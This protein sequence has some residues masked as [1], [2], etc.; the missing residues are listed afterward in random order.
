[1]HPHLWV[2]FSSC[3]AEGQ[4]NVSGSIV[5]LS[6]SDEGDNVGEKSA[7]NKIQAQGLSREESRKCIKA[8]TTKPKTFTTEDA[9]GRKAVVANGSHRGASVEAVQ[10][11]DGTVSKQGLSTTSIN[12]HGQMRLDMQKQELKTKEWDIICQAKE[13]GVAGMDEVAAA[14]IKQHF[15]YLLDTNE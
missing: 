9:A 7:V 8:A 4:L 6:V 1:M 13:A 11:E 12:V 2:V 10:C 5:T 3:I 14:F 15:A